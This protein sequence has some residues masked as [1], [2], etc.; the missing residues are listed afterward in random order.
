MH[1]NFETT[2]SPSLTENG[3]EFLQ[4][5]E[6]LLAENLTENKT[7]NEIDAE[8]QKLNEEIKEI[9][10]D[11]GKKKQMETLS[12]DETEIFNLIIDAKKIIQKLLLPQK[13]IKTKK[14]HQADIVKN[15][16]NSPEIPPELSAKFILEF[17]KLDPVFHNSYL[18][19]LAGVLMNEDKVQRITGI[20]GI[21]LEISRIN[22][23]K[24]QNRELMLN[25]KELI[26]I[27]FSA[28]AKALTE[29]SADEDF[30]YQLPKKLQ[31]NI[32]KFF[33]FD[34]QNGVWKLKDSNTSIKD[35]T[36]IFKKTEMAQFLLKAYHNRS[37][38]QE[39]VPNKIEIDVPIARKENNGEI[40]PYI[41]ET[42]SYSRRLFGREPSNY[43]QLLKYQ[44]AIEQKIVDGASIEIEGRIDSNFRKWASGE[45]SG[46]L[47]PIPNIEIIFSLPLP[48]GQEYRC[49]LKKSA[50]GNGVS[51]L[52]AE[53][54][55]TAEDQ[56]IIAGMQAAIDDKSSLQLLSE[57]KAEDFDEDLQKYLAIP[58]LI[59]DLEI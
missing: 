25:H 12:S 15:L 9:L 29:F 37:V 53:E 49:I 39:L 30:V 13:E 43:N 7:P 55:Y 58:E 19:M 26:P 45:F 22:L 47:G 14:D 2:R 16:E 10:R 20:K 51:I 36:A 3:K 28:Y 41:Y 6:L 8:M 17:N 40:K 50:N 48:S 5:V 32:L 1:P 54:N 35:L 4:K 42:K 11:F 57:L 31:E 24:T 21:L 52:N 38:S 46:D 33:V 56:T 44:A 34:P 23:I 18:Q 27:K 59:K